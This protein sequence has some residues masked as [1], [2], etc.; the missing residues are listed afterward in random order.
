[1]QWKYWERSTRAKGM[2]SQLCVR[3]L[4]W[5]S[6]FGHWD[7]NQTKT[8]LGDDLTLWKHEAGFPVR[9]LK[10]AVAAGVQSIVQG[11]RTVE[12][13]VWH[14]AAEAGGNSLYHCGDGVCAGWDLGD[15]WGPVK[16][17]VRD[18]D[19]SMLKMMWDGPWKNP[20]TSAV[21]I[22][23]HLCERNASLS[24]LLGP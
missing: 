17:G 18:S 3:T 7:L 5:K 8:H 16:K 21:D 2:K 9:L 19:C 10:S 12:T 11:L 22:C 4:W 15:I 1:M 13:G 24:S 14:M 6:S 23:P 20:T